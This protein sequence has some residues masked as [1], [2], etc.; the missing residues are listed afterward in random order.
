M[1][2]ERKS[3][4]RMD[5]GLQTTLHN[6]GNTEQR[7][8]TSHCQLPIDTKVLKMLLKSLIIWHHLFIR[9]WTLC[10]SYANKLLCY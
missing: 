6:R 4:G 7:E 1:K 9:P 2:R 3:H 5:K 10:F 8:N